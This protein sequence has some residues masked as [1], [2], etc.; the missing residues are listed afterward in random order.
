MNKISLLILFLILFLGCGIAQRNALMREKFPY[1]S[2]A[3]KKAIQEHYIIEGMN[4][5]QVYLSLG[6]TLCT[7][8]RYYKG[9]STVVWSYQSDGLTGKPAG[10]TYDCA[11]AYIN[12]YFENGVVVGLV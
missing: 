7:S 12:V 9:K 11:R 8:S 3:I 10:G 1:Y 4:E 2:Q 6:L 5:E